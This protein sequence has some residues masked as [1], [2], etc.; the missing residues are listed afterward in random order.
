MIVTLSIPVDRS[1]QSKVRVDSL[2]RLT[3]QWDRENEGVQRRIKRHKRG[4]HYIVVFEGASQVYTSRSDIAHGE[5]HTVGE[6]A[7]D[8][9]VPLHLVRGTGILFNVRGGERADGEQLHDLVREAGGR[10]WVHG[11]VQSERSGPRHLAEEN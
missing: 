4:R 7:L 6:L 10:R 5:R 2:N 1:D 3:R 9:Q 11:A 8:I